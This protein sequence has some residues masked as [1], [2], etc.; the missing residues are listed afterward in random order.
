MTMAWI[1]NSP[2]KGKRS[3]KHDPRLV[4]DPDGVFR[5]FGYDIMLRS[6][7]EEGHDVTAWLRRQLRM[8]TPALST[9][10]LTHAVPRQDFVE[11]VFLVPDICPAHLAD[12]DSFWTELQEDVLSPTQHLWG[13]PTIW[14]PLATSHHVPFR[15]VRRFIEEEF[16]Q[17]LD[18]P[19]H[20]VAHDPSRVAGGGDYHIHVVISSRAV[21]P[22]GL[23]KFVPAIVHRGCQRAMWRAWSSFK[24]R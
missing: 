4:T 16:V 3:R 18:T 15:Q 7:E 13:G 2:T 19:A 24:P 5:D 10:P 12:A 9:A 20:L 22:R 23:G 14:F 8:N 1:G 11:N 17:K 6:P 21:G